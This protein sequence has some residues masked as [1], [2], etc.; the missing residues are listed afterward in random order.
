[1]ALLGGFWYIFNCLAEEMLS[2]LRIFCK[3]AS[4]YR[5]LVHVTFLSQGREEFS[6]VLKN[7]AARY[8]STKS[9]E[10]MYFI[11]LSYNGINHTLSL[12]QGT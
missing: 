1:M 8:K 5:R 9:N 11:R 6:G 12:L 3:N 7:R 4:F 10:R 2:S